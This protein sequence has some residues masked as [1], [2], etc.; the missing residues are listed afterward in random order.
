MGWYL[1]QY[2]DRCITRTTLTKPRDYLPTFNLANSASKVAIMFDNCQLMYPLTLQ[3]SCQKKMC[4]AHAH[5]QYAVSFAHA[6]GHAESVQ[7][8][9]PGRSVLHQDKQF[10]HCSLGKAAPD[11]AFIILWK[12]SSTVFFSLERLAKMVKLWSPRQ[13]MVYARWWKRKQFDTAVKVPRNP[14]SLQIQSLK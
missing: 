7:P 8:R 4:S 12:R 5:Y 2:I 11:F 6:R 10:C 9:C 14:L 3:R 13:S 1:G